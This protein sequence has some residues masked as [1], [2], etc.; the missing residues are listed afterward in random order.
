MQYPRQ[1]WYILACFVGFITLARWLRL[2]WFFARRNKS[3]QNCRR[4]KPSLLRLPLAAADV[5]RT[6]AFRWTIPIGQSHVL[7]LTEVIL[8]IVYVTLMFVWS[9]MNTT[10]LEGVKYDLLYWTNVSGNIASTQLPLLIGLGMK[11]NVISLLTGVSFNKLN[12]MHRMVARVLCILTWL[13]GAGRVSLSTAFYPR[14]IGKEMW[15]HNW[16]QCGLLGSIAISL[17]VLLS[18]RPLREAGYEFFLL[19]HF[20]LA[21]IFLVSSYF[22]VQGADQVGYLVWP[23]FL[24]WGIDRLL[25]GLRIIVYNI[26]YLRGGKCQ[27]L[28]ATVEILAPKF[29]RLTVYRSKYLHWSP[30]Q[31]VYLT[32]PNTWP[33]PF[34]THPFT[35]ASVDKVDN[36]QGHG[37]NGELDE[38]SRR[39]M[40]ELTFFIKVRGGFTKRLHEIASAGQSL[41]VLVDGPYGVPPV[42]RGY[43]TIVLIAGG[44]GISLTLPLLLHQI[45]LAKTEQRR[46]NRISF[47]WSI[48]QSDHINWISRSLSRHLQKLPDGFRV[49]IQIFITSVKGDALGWNSAD[50]DPE[51]SSNNGDPDTSSFRELSCVQ[52]Q[53][54]RPNL[55]TLLEAE[56]SETQEAMSVNV[57]GPFELINAVRMAVRNPR[58]LEILNGAPMV[59]LHVETFGT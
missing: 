7:N 22:H 54:G 31:S 8:T 3:L 29:L 48:R 45:N 15:G 39:D 9:L 21:M 6:A 41:R 55:E 14:L 47:V 24:V 43:D 44:S 10:N 46:C 13:H 30:A 32:L 23:S 19:M 40:K 49:D 52:V 20:I 50:V 27:E 4:A 59:T 51:K 28:N 17:L 18:I 34:E 33:I 37:R 56:L 12:Y 58:P 57:C 42:F 26:S 53:R 11:N 25:R 35:I 2:A 36:E 38:K 5:F 1:L 16:V